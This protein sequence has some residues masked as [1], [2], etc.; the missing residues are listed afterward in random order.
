MEKR[1]HTIKINRQSKRSSSLHC[2]ALYKRQEEGHS[3]PYNIEKE[4][5]SLSLSGNL[6]TQLRSSNP[7]IVLDE[8]HSAH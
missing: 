6:Q 5:N 4:I 2:T 8:T 3:S 7:Q 1:K